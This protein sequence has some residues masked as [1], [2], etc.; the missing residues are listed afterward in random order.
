MHDID[1]RSR[2][3]LKIR[4]T[5]ERARTVDLVTRERSLSLFTI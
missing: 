4:L 3:V 1:A 2:P 5:L